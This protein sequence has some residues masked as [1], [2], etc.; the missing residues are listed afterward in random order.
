L[1]VKVV[2]GTFRF[3]FKMA[4]AVA[5]VALVAGLYFGGIRDAAGL[6]GKKNGPLASP[7]EL[8][9]DAKSAV[10]QLHQ[11]EKKQERVLKKIEDGTR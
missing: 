1:V 7:L 3:A 2:L 6:T 9:D 4:L 5:L 11:A 8:V 10:D